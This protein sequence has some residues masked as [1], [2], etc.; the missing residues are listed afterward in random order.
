MS[1]HDSFSRPARA[2]AAGLAALALMVT[3]APA[4]AEMPGDVP[5][6][7]RFEVG[8]YAVDAFTE[9]AL[10]SSSAGI[11]AT[12]NFEEI[13]DLPS[14]TQVLSFAGTWKVGKRQYIDFGYVQIRRVG[15]KELDEEVDWGDFVF[16]TGAEVGALFDTS[17][18]YAAWRYDFLQLEQVRISGSAGI[19][20]LTIEAGLA[21]NGSVTD[22]NGVAVTGEVEESFDL[23]VPVPQV[24]LQLD[25]ALTRRL[26]M[27]F[28][29]RLLGIKT[30]D[31]NGSIRQSAIRLYWYFTKHFGIN[32]GLD[33]YDIDL[34]EFTSGDTTARFRY[35]VKGVSLYFQAAF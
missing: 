17:F 26:S 11:G 3:A 34:K 32:G 12:V 30:G 19:N 13:F 14:N 24:G 9:G 27:K 15:S 2:F 4:R 10:S 7:F 31:I 28:Y 29:A 21:A 22:P 1:L 35:E 25:W 5:E 16:Q 20:Y 33:T 23:A 18:P 6:R 8:G